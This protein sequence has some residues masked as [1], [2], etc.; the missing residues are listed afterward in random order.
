MRQEMKDGGEQDPES[1]IPDSLGW[2]AMIRDAKKRIKDLELLIRVLEK[3]KEAG[4]RWPG[5]QSQGQGAGRQQAVRTILQFP[6][7]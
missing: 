2:D 1:A 7:S 6:A 3:K 4:E 5:V